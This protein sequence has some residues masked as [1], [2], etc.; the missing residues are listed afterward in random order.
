MREE[1]I[2]IR[3][4]RGT[5]GTE[6]REE[7]CRASPAPKSILK[8]SPRAS[9]TEATVKGSRGRQMENLD[10]PTGIRKSEEY[11]FDGKER[12]TQGAQVLPGTT[13]RSFETKGGCP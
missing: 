13:W 7:D 4:A 10:H 6:Q 11:E 5:A 1:I 2:D 9:Q 3:E 8:R 12:T